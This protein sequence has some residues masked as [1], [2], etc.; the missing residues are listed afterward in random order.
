MYVYVFVL[1]FLT[2]TEHYNICRLQIYL[3]VSIDMCS[4]S[5][6]E[7]KSCVVLPSL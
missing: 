5:S 1:R 7:K 3:C 2:A 4:F 6:R